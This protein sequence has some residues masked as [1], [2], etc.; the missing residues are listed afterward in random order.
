MARRSGERRRLTVNTN[1]AMRRQQRT[2]TFA[3]EQ[4]CCEKKNL[5]RVLLEN[6]REMRERNIVNIDGGGGLAVNGGD[7]LQRGGGGKGKDLLGSER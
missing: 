5:M 1:A 6:R 3:D 7:G 4:K 2:E